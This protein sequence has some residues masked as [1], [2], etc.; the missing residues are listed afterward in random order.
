M[1]TLTERLAGIAGQQT[2][3]L[4]HHGRK[5]GKP[6][7]VVIWFMVE[8]DRLY[9]ATANVNRNWVRNVKKDPK[10]LLRAGGETFSG[11]V[12]EMT[13]ASEREHVQG[14]VQQKYW[15]V[16]PFLLAARALTMFGILSDHS[17]AFEVRLD[18]GA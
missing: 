15:Y 5:T 14:L 11:E 4:T 2:L 10:V 16:I 3:K 1:A 12:R 6:Y 9:L 17:G 18:P 8:G 13:D 7:E